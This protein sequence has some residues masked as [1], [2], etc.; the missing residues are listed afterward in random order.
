M[1]SSSPAAIAGIAMQ[2]KAI[3]IAS[4]SASSFLVFF[5][6]DSSIIM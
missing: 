3:I 2:L 4:T 6:S 5:I 1:I